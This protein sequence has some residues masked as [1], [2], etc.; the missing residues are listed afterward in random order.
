MFGPLSR[1]GF[2]GIALI[3]FALLGLRADGAIAAPSVSTKT[4]YY[5]VYASTSQ[6]LKS[7]MRLHGPKGFWAYARWYVRWTSKCRLSV[8][9]TYTMPKW[10]NKASAPKALQR[11][12]ERMIKKLWLHER[13]HGRHGIMAAKEIECVGCRHAKRIARKWAEQDKIYDRRTKH[14]RTQ[15]VRLP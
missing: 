15:G 13:G 8:E 6:Q 14:G 5:E 12:W 11:R 1:A 9:I 10:V 7:Q 2:V 4:I 3:T